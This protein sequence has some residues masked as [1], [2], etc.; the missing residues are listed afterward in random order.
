MYT[1]ATRRFGGFQAGRIFAVVSVYRK[2]VKHAYLA[3]KPQN[4]S[5]VI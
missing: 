1:F 5:F 3:L 2:Y 4:Q